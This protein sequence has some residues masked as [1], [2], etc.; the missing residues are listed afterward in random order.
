MFIPKNSTVRDA[1]GLSAMKDSVPD[2]CC[3][4]REQSGSGAGARVL[5]MTEAQTTQTR[6]LIYTVIIS[7]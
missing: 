3:S 4:R 6:A 7:V 2:S 5:A 1:I